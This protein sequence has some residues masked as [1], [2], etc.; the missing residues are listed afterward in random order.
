MPCLAPRRWPPIPLQRFLKKVTPGD[1]LPGAEAFGERAGEPAAVPLLKDG[2]KV[3]YGFLN[4]DF[5]NA[6][7]YSGK[8]I[9][10]MLGLDLE[11]RITGLVLVDHKEPI[12]LI[13]IPEKKIRDV[14]DGYIGLDV[15]AFARVRPVPSVTSISSAA[16]RSRSW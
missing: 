1:L 15:P 12:V 14:I 7:G 9:H 3:G 8:P 11:G 6:A 4:S 13:G 16:P 10:V 2:Q 5:V